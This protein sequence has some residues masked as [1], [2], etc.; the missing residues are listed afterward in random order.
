M[1][2][3][4]ARQVMDFDLLV[5]GFPVYGC[6]APD[7]FHAYLDRLPPGTGRGAFA[8]CTK[9]AF[10]GGAVRRILQRLAAQ[11][12]VPLG[13][14][15]VTMP[16]T[17]G[18][19]FVGKGS[20]L[21][22]KALG[23]DYDHLQDADRLAEQ[24]AHTF[25]A[26]LDGHPLETLRQPSSLQRASSPSDRLWAL[27][28]ETIGDY[29][30]SK[31]RVDEGCQACGLCA[32]ICP[33]ENVELRQGSPHFAGHC[34]LCMRCIHACPQEAIQI[35]QATVG[36]FRWR[37]PKGGFDPLRLRPGRRSD[38]PDE[39]AMHRF[40]GRRLSTETKQGSC[41]SQRDA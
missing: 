5:A 41:R 15:S 23:K 40:A 10:A 6:D 17:D 32:R 37:G 2:K 3:Q 29:A 35:G 21:A 11:G 31:L 4:A 30:R 14:G 16:G 8:F 12:Y 20:W 38:S 9:G 1:E 25:S 13:G 19:A 24:M 39:A 34:A 27:L 22:R 18:L 33:V 26:L 7:F 28:Y 36:K